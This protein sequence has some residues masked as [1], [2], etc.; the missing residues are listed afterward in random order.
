[1]FERF[2]KLGILVRECTL[3]CTIRLHIGECMWW[4]WERG[5]TDRSYW[6]FFSSTSNK[7]PFTN[8]TDN[9]RKG[10]DQEDSHAWGPNSKTSNLEPSKNWWSTF[11]QKYP[12]PKVSQNVLFLQSHILL[13]K[14]L[15]ATSQNV[16]WFTP[17]YK[18]NYMLRGFE[19]LF[20]DILLSLAFCSTCFAVLH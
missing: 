12:K 15:V 3:V 7:F 4:T 5:Q 6:K 16:T 2:T 8:L 9:K 13:L 17:K 19:F 10:G 14:I 20:H 18:S 11:L 1:M